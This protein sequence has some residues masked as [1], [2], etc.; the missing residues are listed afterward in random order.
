MVQS[1]DCHLVG[2]A[3]GDGRVRQLGQG[4]V[5]IL[6]RDARGAVT[7]TRVQE[8]RQPP[9]EQVQQNQDYSPETSAKST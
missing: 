8:Q 7:E 9:R 6:D 4:R 2:G 5:L 1:G 3:D